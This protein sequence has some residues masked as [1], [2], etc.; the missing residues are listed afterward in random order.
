MKYF[1]DIV[2]YFKLIEIITDSDYF[3]WS[4]KSFKSIKLW[5]YSKWNWFYNFKTVFVFDNNILHK[6]ICIREVI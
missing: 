4:Y 2:L 5:L 1:E 6:E 3:F